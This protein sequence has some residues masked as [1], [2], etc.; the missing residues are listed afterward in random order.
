M[1][2]GSLHFGAGLLSPTRPAL[3][4]FEIPRLQ[5]WIFSTGTFFLLALVGGEPLAIRHRALLLHRCGRLLVWARPL[6]AIYIETNYRAAPQIRSS[7]HPLFHCP[8]RS[9]SIG[10]QGSEVSRA[11]SYETTLFAESSVAEVPPTLQQL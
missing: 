4:L 11:V 9:A 8:R 10:L 6:G 7:C 1:A 3:S 2:L 5:R